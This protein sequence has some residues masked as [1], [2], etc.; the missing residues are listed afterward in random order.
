M[1]PSRSP[2]VEAVVRRVI[3]AWQS[4]DIE[5]MSNL[6]SSDPAL[7]VTGFD[8][9]ERWVGPD[10]FL[11][12]F[13]TQ[14]GEWPSWTEEV[15]HVDAFQDGPFGWATIFSTLT[16]PETS[17]PIR[18]TG[19]LRL[20][21]GSWRII[22]WHNA[23]PVSNRQIF[24]VELTTTLDELVGSIM[25]DSR[26]LVSLAGTEGTTT[27][28]FTDIVDSTALA[29][30]MGDTEWANTVTAH[31][32]LLHRISAAEGG[33]VVKLLGD[34][35]MLA[36]RSSRGAVRAAIEIL[37][38]V[39]TAPF[40]V[41]IGIHTGDVIS[42]GEDYLGTTVNK[43]AR[44]AAAAG[45]SEILVSST[46]AEMVGSTPGIRMEDRGLAVLKGLSGSHHI[47]SVH[48]ATDDLLPGPEELAL[49]T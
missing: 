13:R 9:G 12:I 10:E 3:A 4:R 21:R 19:T 41:R 2:E 32:A 23:I 20:E 17:S 8:P 15:T 6:F 1:A 49:P 45:A 24:G 42:T 35:S 29:E 22:Q 26:S 47:Y 33:A 43:A 28:V 27:L 48:G 11:S 14:S 34:G 16:T 39:I 40:D 38:S 31:G 46:T 18:H 5:T 30:T 36:F 7:R 37:R 44:I 25:Q